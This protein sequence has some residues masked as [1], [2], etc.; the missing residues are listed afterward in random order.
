SGSG[1]LEYEKE[2]FDEHLI[3]LSLEYA[4]RLKAAC[5]AFDFVFKGQEPLVVEISYGFAAAGYD[6]CPGYWDSGLQWQ[7]GSFNPYGWMIEFVR[8]EVQCKNKVQ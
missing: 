3:S 8:R 2:L 4:R 6:P 5:V 7:E 1:F